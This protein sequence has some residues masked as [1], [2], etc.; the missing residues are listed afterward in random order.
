MHL[1]ENLQHQ[2]Y[3]EALLPDD[4]FLMMGRA[5]GCVI[6]GRTR[7]QLPSSPL[8]LAHAVNHPPEGRAANVLQAAY[9]YPSKCTGGAGGLFAAGSKDALYF[10]EHLRP[11]IPNR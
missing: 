11:F 8:T 9:D 4:N 3:V 7:D 5:D 6:D 1:P 10:P 2:D